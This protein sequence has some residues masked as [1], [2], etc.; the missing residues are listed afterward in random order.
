MKISTAH[1]EK[2]LSSN[3][4]SASDGWLHFSHL[5]LIF[6]PRKTGKD[7]RMLSANSW[8]NCYYSVSVSVRILLLGCVYNKPSIWNLCTPYEFHFILAFPPKKSLRFQSSWRQ[9]APA[10]H[11]CKGLCPERFSML[12]FMLPIKTVPELTWFSEKKDL[13][14]VQ[15]IT[16]QILN[17]RGFLIC[18]SCSVRNK[19]KPETISCSAAPWNGSLFWGCCCVLCT[20]RG[21]RLYLGE[22][23]VP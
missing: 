7:S 14:R 21:S 4:C 23:L 2:I 11:S 20:F 18:N 12:Q 13:I 5:D 8:S 17:D 1:L 22:V 10:F 16:K 6:P 9:I 19:N 3:T 15:H